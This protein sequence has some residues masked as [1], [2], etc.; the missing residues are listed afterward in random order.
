MILVY[1]VPMALSTLGPVDDE[2]VV[3]AAVRVARSITHNMDRQAVDRSGP[4]AVNSGGPFIE[5]NILPKRAGHGPSTSG[6]GL[7][8]SDRFSDILGIHSK[9]S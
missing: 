8:F 3:C 7:C 2:K 1:R 9:A 6:L 5:L 4:V